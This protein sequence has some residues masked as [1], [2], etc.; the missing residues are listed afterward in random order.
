MVS[1]KKY[2]EKVKLIE[3][4]KLY[5]PENAFDLVKATAFAKFDESVDL[6]V[7]LGVDPKKSAVRGTVMLPAGSGKTKKV[8]VIVKADKV[9]EAEE[10][11]AAVVGGDD[12]VAKIQGGFLDFDVL[13]VTPDMMVAVGKLG[14][15][16]GPKGLMPNPKTGT[17]TNDIGKTVKEF[18]GGKVEF[19]MDKT[20]LL[21]MTLGK[22]SFAKDALVKNFNASL[23]AILHSKPSGVKGQYLRSITVSST[24]GPGVKI[25]HQAVAESLGKE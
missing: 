21:H 5:S 25:D 13:V 24:M 7:R 18:A 15:V 19:K 3:K 8:A 1:G 2:N 23:L 22:V 12:L 9:K 10:A 4:G 6:S 14:K 17:V 11:G 16:L 20:S